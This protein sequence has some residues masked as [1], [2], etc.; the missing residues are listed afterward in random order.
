MIKGKNDNIN[1]NEVDS[2]SQMEEIMARIWLQPYCPQC[3]TKNIH[4]A[5]RL[6]EYTQKAIQRRNCHCENG[7]TKYAVEYE[8]LIIQKEWDVINI[9]NS[10]FTSEHRG[11]IIIEN[12]KIVNTKVHCQKCS[13]AYDIYYDLDWG[14]RKM[15]DVSE[16]SKIEIFCIEC[17][18]ELAYHKT[19][20]EEQQNLGLIRINSNM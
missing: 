5:E 20:F 8:V 17:E 12:H 16:E 3:G 18:Y 1:S 4:I 2:N 11:V 19:L 10:G 9:G 6:Q 14:D 7:D 15:F 13:E